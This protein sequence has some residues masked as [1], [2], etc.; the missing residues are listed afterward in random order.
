MR[1]GWIVLLA[2][3]FAGCAA[4]VQKGADVQPLTVDQASKRNLVL[5][6][7]GSK[8]SLGSDDWEQMKADWRAAF[9]AEASRIGA[10]LTFQDIAA[11]PTGETGTLIVVYLNDYRYVS[12]GAR[13]GLGV[14]TGNAYLDAQVRFVNAKTG[15][16]LGERSYNTSS[17]AWQG[18]F[19]A[20][21]DKQVQAIAQDVLAEIQRP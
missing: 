18:I 9:K 7:T 14:M 2:T 6:V 8:Q 5:N 16:V 10:V 12:T 15:Q 4:I 17:S 21:T 11:K 1:V 3:M 20:M 13:Y 19:S